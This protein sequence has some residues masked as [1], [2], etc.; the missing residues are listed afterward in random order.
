[1]ESKRTLI[2]SSTNVQKFYNGFLEHLMIDHV[3]INPRHT[4]VQ[5]SLRKIIKQGDLVLDLGCGTGISTRFIAEQGAKVI[6]VD[7][8]PDLIGYAQ[9]NSAH[10]NAEYHCADITDIN[11]NGDDFYNV[12]VLSDEFE[13][14]DHPKLKI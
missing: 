11:F 13:H 9:V 8:S 4:K 10:P 7:I 3:R 12:I 5:H 6:G 2:P 14:I 1:M